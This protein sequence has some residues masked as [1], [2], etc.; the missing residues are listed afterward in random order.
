MRVSRLLT[1]AGHI[2]VF[3]LGLRMCYLLVRYVSGSGNVQR[4][5]V[6]SAAFL[7]VVIGVCFRLWRERRDAVSAS[8]SQRHPLLFLIVSFALA[9]GL[10]WPA[11]SIGFLSDDV[12]LVERAATW[13]LGAVTR[14]LFRPLPLAVWALI[15]QVGAGAKTI[16]AL[17]IALHAINAWLTKRLA[18]EWVKDKWAAF[19]AGLLMVVM[20]LAPEAVVWSAGV[21]DVMAT[22][23]ALTVILVARRYING[24]SFKLRVSFVAVGVL[25]LLAKETA[26]VV[27]L[28]VV[29]DGWVRKKFPRPLLLDTA[30][31][32][33]VVGIV[34]A[35]RLTIRYGVT[36]PPLTRRFVRRA[37]FRSFGGLAFP[38]HT[39]LLETWPTVA[40]LV[41]L[42]ISALVIAFV[43]QAGQ[44][45]TT[46]VAF[47]CS[48]WILIGI[49][50]VFNVFFISDDLQSSRY[51]YLSSVGWSVLLV[52][53]IW[54]LPSNHS[55]SLA[56]KLF[57][58]MFLTGASAFGSRV[59]LRPWIEAA[60]LRDTVMREATRAQQTGSCERMSV[61]NLP[62]NVR[63]AYVFRVSAREQLSRAV[64]VQVSV[65]D[66]PG[67][68]SFRWQEERMI[69]LSNN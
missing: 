37:L 27:P 30:V 9:F 23:L 66:E 43:L 65:I 5:H 42:V 15:L 7:L 63:G 69:F 1:G 3:V 11:L 41:A 47:A 54:D 12:G 4:F 67:P 35:I 18:V 31:L 48:A 2:L 29:V 61:S 58:F 38:W 21:F 14:E 8:T 17:N 40:L 22:M 36:A 46:R 33:V 39:D 20:P 59:H 55:W 25:A 64:G 68:C 28:L 44:Q 32:V 53:L 57:V 62:D 60:A 51:L 13:R 50:P 34:A 56:V 24:P 10:Y 19:G 26:A 49:L 6:E 52:T 45:R 16:H